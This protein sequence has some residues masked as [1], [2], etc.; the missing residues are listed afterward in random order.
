MVCVDS[1]RRQFAFN[2]G[3]AR[4]EQRACANA[5]GFSR[6]SFHN[7]NERI[8]RWRGDNQRM[9][10]GFFFKWDGVQSAV[11]AHSIEMREKIKRPRLRSRQSAKSG[12][13]EPRGI[14]AARRFAALHL[15]QIA[16]DRLHVR[17]E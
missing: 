9:S 3:I 15:Y 8:S 6:E 14:R 12:G 11:L 13:P 10:R 1:T 7:L 2:S 16:P 17:S 4:C 5:K